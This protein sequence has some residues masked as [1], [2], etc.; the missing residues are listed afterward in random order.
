MSS[1]LIE[2]GYLNMFKRTENFASSDRKLIKKKKNQEIFSV[3]IFRYPVTG[4]IQDALN[5][6][7]NGM[8]QKRMKKLAYDDLFHL[9]LL[10][11][12]KFVF[13]KEEVP[14][15]FSDKNWI[16]NN[17]SKGIEIMDVPVP[18]GY[19]VSIKEFISNAETFMGKSFK[20]YSALK[21]NC[22][23]F[24]M[25]VL[26]ANGLLTEQNKAFI[27]QDVKTLFKN[28]PKLEKFGQVLTDI[29]SIANHIVHGSGSD[30]DPVSAKF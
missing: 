9:G 13:H 10:I 7:T 23:H 18:A 16:K 5:F 8:L 20:Q 1:Q 2:G 28:Y 3:Q 11:N 29:G 24:A 19:E 12:G 15:F 17:K 4:F 25:S 30:S 21:F 6:M 27:Y 22:Q 26:K 14:K